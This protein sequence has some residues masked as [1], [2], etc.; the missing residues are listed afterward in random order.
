MN[1]NES[2][3]QET[4]LGAEQLSFLEG[5]ASSTNLVERQED[6][7]FRVTDFPNT[8]ESPNA[9][10]HIDKDGRITSGHNTEEVERI[11]NQVQ[12]SIEGK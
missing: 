4:M 2:L 11:L 3:L 1:R 12:S 5:A 7:G 8:V 9:S 6:G 10:L